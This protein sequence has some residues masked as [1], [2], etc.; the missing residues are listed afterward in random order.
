MTENH[1]TIRFFILPFSSCIDIFELIMCP[2]HKLLGF[3]SISVKFW[4]E[5][6]IYNTFCTRITVQNVYKKCSLYDDSPKTLIYLFYVQNL[7]YYGKT[8]KTWLL[9]D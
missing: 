1:L 4:L 9:K 6:G 2:I 5:G 8:W 7:H 3:D